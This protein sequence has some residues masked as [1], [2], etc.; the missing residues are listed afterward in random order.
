MLVAEWVANQVRHLIADLIEIL[1]K[2]TQHMDKEHISSCTRSVNIRDWKPGT[3]Q[4]IYDL[5]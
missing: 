3:Q 5:H 1:F 4:F 2:E